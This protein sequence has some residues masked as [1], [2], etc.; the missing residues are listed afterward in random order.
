MTLPHVKLNSSFN[1]N[2][3]ARA[4]FCMAKTL[5][6]LVMHIPNRHL[7]PQSPM[8]AKQ[9]PVEA[10]FKVAKNKQLI[11][12]IAN[13]SSRNTK[14]SWQPSLEQKS[15]RCFKRQLEKK[16]KQKNFPS[17]PTLLLI[18]A[19]VIGSKMVQG[20]IHIQL[21]RKYDTTVENSIEINLFII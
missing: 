1:I 18:E 13:I 21:Q 8:E 7:L 2:F 19:T 6:I 16:Q 4:L 12:A 17:R 15:N 20:F 11:L 14:S 5:N 9:S 10:E 3:Q